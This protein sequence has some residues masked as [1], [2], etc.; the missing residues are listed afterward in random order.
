MSLWTINIIAFYFAERGD[1][2]YSFVF[3]KD[4]NVHKKFG[5]SVQ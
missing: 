3:L 4:N 5:Q 1:L 2:I